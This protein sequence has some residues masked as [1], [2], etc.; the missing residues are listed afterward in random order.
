MTHYP[1]PRLLLVPLTWLVML[2]VPGTVQAQNRPHVEL[3]GGVTWL[4]TP[5]VLDEPATGWVV[6]G[7]WNLT[8]AVGLE[9]QAG[10]LEQAQS[11][12]FLEVNA[13]F[14][15][16]LVGPMIALRRGPLHPFAHVLVG[17]TQL[18]LIVASDVPFSS[19]GDSQDTDGTLLL[20]GGVDLPLARRF[21]ARIAYDYRRVFAAAR[22]YQHGLS[23][24][25]VYGLGGS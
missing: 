5:D 22:F 4:G 17:T 12:T 21:R 7:I 10:R 20:G 13:R 18:D 2:G 8:D 14:L 6:G 24:S 3:L 9:L 19:S 16:V 1:S 11:V 25:A 23:A 15:T